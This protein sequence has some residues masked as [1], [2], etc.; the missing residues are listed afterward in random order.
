M[1][2]FSTVV[3]VIAYREKL[4]RKPLESIGRAFF[5]ENDFGAPS[6]KDVD[7]VKR[8]LDMNK[9][10]PP[11]TGRQLDLLYL[12]AYWIFPIFVF[13]IPPLSLYSTKTQTKIFQKMAASRNYF[14]R[15]L[16]DAVKASITMVYMSHEKV[17]KYIGEKD[18]CPLPN[19]PF[20][21]PKGKFP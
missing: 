15:S 7:L 10:L 3:L 9:M 12:A 19:D 16:A 5:P 8:T 13:R 11:K 14:I 4:L 20:K 6:W 18:H 21:I 17:V 1:I 2:A